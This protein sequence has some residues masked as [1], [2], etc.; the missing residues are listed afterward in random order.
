MP[1]VDLMSRYDSQVLNETVHAS[2]RNLILDACEYFDWAC[3]KDLGIYG[4]ETPAALINHVVGSM[5]EREDE[6][7]VILLNGDFVSHGVALGRSDSHDNQ[8]LTATWELMKGTIRE[9]MDLMRRYYPNT[10]FLPSIGNNDVIV[11]NN[12]PCNNATADVYY[13]E[14]FDIWFNEG[15]FSE[16]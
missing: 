1:P 13:P 12:L 7:D 11:H 5:K 9:D 6:F 16:N 14:L 8:T 3:H 15:N 2:V 10:D 4:L